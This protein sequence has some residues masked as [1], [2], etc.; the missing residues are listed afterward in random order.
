MGSKPKVKQLLSQRTGN[1]STHSIWW[2]LIKFLEGSQDRQETVKVDIISGRQILNCYSVGDGY[3]GQPVCS[4]CS[5]GSDVLPL[6]VTWP[7][8]VE[9]YGECGI[10]MSMH[11][12]PTPL[13]GTP[14]SLP[15]LGEHVSVEGN[16]PQ[17]ALALRINWLAYSVF[18]TWCSLVDNTRGFGLPSN[19]SGSTPLCVLIVMIV[20]LHHDDL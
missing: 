16:D 2:N 1:V 8:V 13:P 18:V 10:F 19:R 7:R 14:V 17:T 12:W 3:R 6:D 4:F 20:S 15:V 5:H 9:C 11:F